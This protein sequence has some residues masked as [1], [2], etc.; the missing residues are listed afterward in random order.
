[1]RLMARKKPKNKAAQ[2]MAR[3]RH[4][5]ATPEQ[6]EEL[7][8]LAREMTRKRLEKMTPEERT[9]H[10]RKAARARWKKRKPK[11]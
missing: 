10:A 2:E 11:E 7:K 9:E 1:M 6:Q 5:K 4:K 3:L 8:E